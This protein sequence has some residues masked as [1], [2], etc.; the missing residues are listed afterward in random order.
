MCITYEKSKPTE[1][2]SPATTLKSNYYNTFG[3]Y[4]YDV[5]LA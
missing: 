1:L 3:E 2:C 5:S 4:L